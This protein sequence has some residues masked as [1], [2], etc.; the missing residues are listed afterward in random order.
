M[1]LD[2]GPDDADSADA[3]AAPNGMTAADRALL[4]GRPPSS[5]RHHGGG[6]A[7]QHEVMRAEIE[8]MK[9]PDAFSSFATGGSFAAFGSFAAGQ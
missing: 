7:D 6:G 3:G 5:S 1:S 4:F 9:R 2:L 8:A